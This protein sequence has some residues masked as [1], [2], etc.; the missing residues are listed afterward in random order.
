MIA[1]VAGYLVGSVSFARVISRFAGR[2]QDVEKAAIRIPDEQKQMELTYVSSTSVGVQAGRRWGCLAAVLDIL[3]AMLPAL[4]FRLLYPQ[5]PLHMIAGAAAVVGHNW[6][7]Y[8][9][10]KGG[11]GISTIWGATLVVDW[12]GLIVSLVAGNL[13][14]SFLIK[15]SLFSSVVSLPLLIL[16]SIVV[17]RSWW[18]VG[19]AVAVSL[20]FFVASIPEYQVYRRY[21]R[22]GRLDEYAAAW[23]ASPM[24]RGR[25]QLDRLLRRVLGGGKKRGPDRSSE[26]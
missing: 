2:G 1:A 4:V 6:P 19:Y 10:F 7:I 26:E 16:W 11:R 17:R 23:R 3:K 9:R 5:T 22:E 14:S 12:L 24:G 20:A 25:A 13:I 8:Y 15:E 21:K 18:N